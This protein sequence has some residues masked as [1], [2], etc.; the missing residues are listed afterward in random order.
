MKHKI[1]QGGWFE[2]SIGSLAGKKAKQEYHDID[3]ALR[4]ARRELYKEMTPE[5]EAGV[6][7]RIENLEAQAA[8]IQREAIESYSREG[9]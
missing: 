1:K 2:D 8:T 4:S 3:L 5:K 6:V 9:A 7:T